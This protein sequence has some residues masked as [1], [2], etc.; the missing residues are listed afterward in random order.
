M[1]DPLM[2]ARHVSHH[3]PVRAP[4]L[5][6]ASVGSIRA[7]D[8]VSLKL[9]RGETLALVGE[10]GCGK[11]TFARVMAFLNRPT[12]GEIRFRGAVTAG[13]DIA[14]VRKEIQ[15]IFQDP[16]GALNPRMTVSAIIS[17]PLR[18]H[19][20]KSLHKNRVTTLMESVGLAPNHGHRYPHEF[21]ACP[22]SSS[23]RS[24]RR[25]PASSIP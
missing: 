17:E 7:V 21:S 11:S 23:A 3:F 20:P 1:T 6:A 22:S 12:A 2:E 4:G 19:H 15:M 14:M 5:F 25:L 16:Y 10:S 18:I 8:D 13:R 9:Y 24:A